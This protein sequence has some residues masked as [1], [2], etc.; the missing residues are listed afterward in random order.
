MYRHSFSI[1]FRPSKRLLMFLIAFK[2]SYSFVVSNS[3]QIFRGNIG[4]PTRGALFNEWVQHPLNRNFNLIRQVVLRSSRYLAQNRKLKP[5]FF[6]K[7]QY[8]LNFYDK[9]QNI[10][11][12]AHTANNRC[13]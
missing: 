5:D 10:N 2:V 3:K 11:F 6:N 13:K 4:F 12:T 8:L 7:L 9:T 1:L